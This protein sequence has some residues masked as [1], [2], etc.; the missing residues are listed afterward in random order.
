MRGVGVRELLIA[1]G[2]LVLGLMLGG[3]GPRAEVRSLQVTLDACEQ[4]PCSPEDL[5]QDLARMFAGRPFAGDDSRPSAPR[6]V[7]RPELEAEA[8][9]DDGPPPMKAPRDDEDPPQE[10]GFDEAGLADGGTD[11]MREVMELRRRQVRAALLEDAA[12]DD[13]QLAEIDAAVGDMNDELYAIAEDLAAQVR[14]GV[15]PSRRET[16]EFAAD[17]LDVLLTAEDRM[18]NSLDDDQLDALDEGAH[19]PLAWVDPGLVD[20]FLELDR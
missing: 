11:A 19:D 17:T 4:R 14:Q 6:P 13:V 3:L 2:A 7:P 1:A 5:G 10:I 20:V 18:L 9:D 15:R 16:M 8:P 12:P